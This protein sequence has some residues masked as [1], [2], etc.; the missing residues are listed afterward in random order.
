MRFV[1]CLP[2]RSN[3]DFVLA[4]LEGRTEKTK[5]VVKEAGFSCEDES[6][7]CNEVPRV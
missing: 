1:T 5:V 3:L 6:N 2:G 7:V 4:W